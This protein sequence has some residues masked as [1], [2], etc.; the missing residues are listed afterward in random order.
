MKL[1][2]ELFEKSYGEGCLMS[3][4]AQAMGF[5]DAHAF[6]QKRD[7]MGTITAQAQKSI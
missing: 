7:Y 2:Y 5:V 4:I 1:L 6:K 3:V